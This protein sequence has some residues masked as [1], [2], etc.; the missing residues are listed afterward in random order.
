[1]TKQ[2]PP[3]P[4]EPLILDEKEF[5]EDVE[6]VQL[7]QTILEDTELLRENTAT[8]LEAENL[9][10]DQMTAI[11][12]LHASDLRGYHASFNLHP[13]LLQIHA[14]GICHRDIKPQNLLLDPKTHV[15][16]L[17]DFGSAKVLVPGEPNVSYICSR[18]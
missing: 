16:K 6:I 11:M 9:T 15:V 17:I 7:P 2:V 10:L 5:A 12:V 4:W 3:L 13:D 18:Y 14:A 8:H 1:M